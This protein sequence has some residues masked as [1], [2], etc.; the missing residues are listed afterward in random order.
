MKEQIQQLIE[1]A[2]STLKED[3]VIAAEIQPRIMIERTRN[4]EHGDF[5]CNVA[6]MLAK[7]AGKP[8][9]D[10]AQLII[11]ALPENEQIA[12][13]EIAGPGFINFYLV[14]GAAQSIVQ[15]IIEQGKN[16]G[17]SDIGKGK[18]ILMEFVSA[19]P[20]GPLHVGHG[21]GAA[22][23]ASMSDLLEL[24]GYQVDREYY[25]NDAGRQMNI[26]AA[27][28]WLRYLSLC[29]EEFAFPS[30]AYKGDYVIAIAQQLKDQYQEQFKFSAAEVFAAVAN[31]ED[32]EEGKD[33]YIDALIAKA[34]EL[35]GEENY[36]T[37]FNLGLDEIVKDIRED[38]LEYGLEYQQW[39]SEK[40]LMDN[41][42]IDHSLERL[43]ELGYAYE[44]EGAIW[45]KST[46]FGD[47]K[48]RVLVRKD[49]RT[50]YFASDVAYHLNK[51]ERGYDLIIDVLGA[52]HHG[53]V[54]RVRAAMRAL[55]VSDKN[56]IVPLVQFA[57]L[58][59]G[60]EKV[61]M[62]T[63]SGSFVTLRE[64]REEIGNDAARFYYV[65]RKVEQHMDF[66]LDL[67]TS[68]SNENPVFYIQYAHARICS[69]FRQAEEKGMT[70]DQ[71]AG[72]ASLSLLTN[73]HEQA[74]FKLLAKYPEVILSAANNYEPHAIITYLRELAN[75]F[76]T[77]YNAE[78]ALVDEA[79]LRNA[80][81]VLMVAVRQV[82]A[83]ALDLLGVSAPE[84]M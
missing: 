74:L 44:Q 30:N 49:G 32:N 46:E 13:A 52:D 16:F 24:V 41:G 39:F 81:L 63:R 1:N 77:Y 83:N 19:N 40:Q 78:K 72:L 54:P 59:R 62:S 33:A 66:D 79:N 6:L 42:A 37:V 60:G 29:G 12:K 9:R 2:I 73:E 23:G 58:Y 7:Q 75:A 80:R 53:Y 36:Q 67:A 47:D 61:Q 4:K 71:A 57:A 3:G 11:S 20:T 82:L 21:R 76:H 31:L 10:L 65:M 27:S 17:R 70:Y 8:P 68:K 22:F 15:T 50:T 84:R 38:L 35:L 64:L 69:V 56:F 18:K 34:Q 43:K 25:V 55:G 48:D 51:I 14:E 28:V 5:A 45:F 26:L